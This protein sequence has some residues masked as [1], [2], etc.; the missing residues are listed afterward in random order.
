MTLDTLPLRDLHQAARAVTQRLL[1]AQRYAPLTMQTA[2]LNRNEFRLF[3][4]LHRIEMCNNTILKWFGRPHHLLPPPVRML[5][6]DTVPTPWCDL[7]TQQQARNGIVY[8]VPL[9][10]LS[11]TSQDLA[12]SHHL[13]RSYAERLGPNAKSILTLLM[14]NRQLT[15][16]TASMH[17]QQGI[18]RREFFRIKRTLLT[19]ERNLPWTPSSCP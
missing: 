14:S 17:C 6:A 11:T 9:D 15:Y 19:L 18:S 5:F 12:L 8:I 16:A 1:P 10:R 2:Y 7:L 13:A 3:L 4:R